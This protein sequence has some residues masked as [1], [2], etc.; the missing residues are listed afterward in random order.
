M[1]K[2]HSLYIPN[3]TGNMVRTKSVDLVFIIF[4]W[5]FK[6]QKIVFLALITLPYVFFQHMEG[7]EMLI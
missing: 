1:N 4:Y 2:G 6:R 7:E 3:C 5:N